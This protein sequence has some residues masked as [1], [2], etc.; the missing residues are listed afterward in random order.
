MNILLWILQILLALHTAMGA[1][2]KLSNTEQTVPALKAIPH[3]MWLTMMVVEVLCSLALI[4]PAFH[5]PLGILVPI[6]TLCIAAEM[7]IFCGLH[8]YAGDKT[9]THVIYWLVVALLCAFIS[10]GR[11]MLKPIC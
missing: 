7:L 5:K 1:I 8:L 6:A 9:Y 11:F 3:G 10:Y 4:I 2:W